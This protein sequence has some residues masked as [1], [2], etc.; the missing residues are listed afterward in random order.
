MIQRLL[1][2]LRRAKGS[3]TLAKKRLQLLLIHDKIELS[4]SEMAQMKAEIVE[5][6]ERYLSVNQEDT[7][8]RL[9]RLENQITLVS[10]IPV[11]SNP[12]RANSAK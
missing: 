11:S 8:F 10:S 1:Q 7:H 4:P 6:I 3:K 2:R 9:D 5:V 12:K